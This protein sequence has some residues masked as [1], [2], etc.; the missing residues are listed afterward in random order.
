MMSP[1]L[2]GRGLLKPN[3]KKSHR[4]KRVHG[5]SD[6]TTKKIFKRF[7]FRLFLFSL[8]AAELSILAVV[9]FQ[10]LASVRAYRLNKA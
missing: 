8:A 1:G 10:A 9:S 3:D 2:G 7:Y 4:G 5:N 6:I